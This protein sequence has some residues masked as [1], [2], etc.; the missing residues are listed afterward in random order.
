MWRLKQGRLTEK[1]RVKTEVFVQCAYVFL[2][3][4]TFGACF[5][6]PNPFCLGR[7][8]RLEQGKINGK[9]EGEKTEVKLMRRRD[10]SA[11]QD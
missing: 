10:F 3:L 6:V 7:V 1:R 4:F 5:R 11:L 8:W 9:T 2:F